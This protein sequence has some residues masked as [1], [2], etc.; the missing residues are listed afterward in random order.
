[1]SE[2]RQGKLANVVAEIRGHA[3]DDQSR[4]VESFGTQAAQRNNG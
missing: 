1:M 3:S 4:E 2:V